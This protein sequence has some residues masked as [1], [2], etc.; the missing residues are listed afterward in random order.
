MLCSS[1]KKV[2][3]CFTII[4]N[5]TVTTHVS[6]NNVRADL[7]SEGNLYNR[8]TNSASMVIRRTR[9][10]NFIERNLKF[11]KLKKVVFQSPCKLNSLFRYN[12]SLQ[13]NICSD[14]VYRCTCSNCK[15]IYYGKTYCLFFTRAAEHM[16]VSI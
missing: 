10:V 9:L 1:S 3:V 16:G 14:I 4:R 15:V 8:T 2:A 11:C 6:V 7:F 12:D 5:L 13:K